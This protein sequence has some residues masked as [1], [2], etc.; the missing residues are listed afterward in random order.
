LFFKLKMN[1][2]FYKEDGFLQKLSGAIFLSFILVLVACG[3]DNGD[4]N[5]SAKVGSKSDYWKKF[6]NFPLQQHMKT[7]MINLFGCL[8]VFL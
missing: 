4:E 5:P 1:I 6:I 3:G 7:K 8:P 2:T